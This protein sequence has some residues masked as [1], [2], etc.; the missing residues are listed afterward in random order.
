MRMIK[1]LTTTY[2]YRKGHNSKGSYY[3]APYTRYKLDKEGKEIEREH[4]AGYWYTPDRPNRKESWAEFCEKKNK[5]C[6]EYK[7]GK[8]SVKKD[9]HNWPNYETYC[10]SGRFKKWKNKVLRAGNYTCQICKVAPAI[11][12]HHVHYRKPWGTELVTD[13]QALCW[14]CHENLHSRRY[15]KEKEQSI[16]C[17]PSS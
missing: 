12:A 14:P 7:D 2:A 15:P 4:K 17:S 9:P 1:N 13:G 10:R 16:K 6:V 3:S 11:S 8:V 5:K